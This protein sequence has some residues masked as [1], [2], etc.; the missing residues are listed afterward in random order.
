MNLCSITSYVRREGKFSRTRV[1]NY[2]CNGTILEEFAIYVD[3]A[4]ELYLFLWC[5]E[6]QGI[7]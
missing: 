2:S 6:S 7:P 5:F 4:N 3:Q 1:N